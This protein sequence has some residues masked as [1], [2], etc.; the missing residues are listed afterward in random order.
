MSPRWARRRSN[1]APEPAGT[2]QAGAV[3]TLAAVD[4]VDA[5]WD[6]LGEVYDPELALD[7][8]SLGLVYDIRREG[9]S[10]VVDMTFTTP[11]CPASE[12]LPE[13]A[14]DAI[15]RSISRLSGD[16]GRLGVE[17]RV[18]WE[19]PWNPSMMNDEAASALGLRDE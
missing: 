8:V 2:A 15:G 6:A 5:A 7:V 1:D 11:G 3:A 16:D 13:M 19:P 18:V 9:D 4:P 14:R 10:I 12:M 17:L